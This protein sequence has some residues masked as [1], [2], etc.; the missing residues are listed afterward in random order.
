MCSSDLFV[1]LYHGLGW[2]ANE[3]TRTTVRAVVHL[4]REPAPAPSFRARA[5]LALATIGVLDAIEVMI[6]VY[7]VIALARVVSRGAKAVGPW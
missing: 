7:I 4:R 3:L 6:L 1:V 5:R 2:A